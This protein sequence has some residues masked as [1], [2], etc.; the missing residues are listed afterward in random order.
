MATIRQELQA[1]LDAL[2]ASFEAEKAPLEAQLAKYDTWLDMEW[3]SF[4]A[5]VEALVA[6]ARTPT[7]A[8]PATAPPA[9][10]LVA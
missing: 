5:E 9:V 7:P 4:K 3:D 8:A 2:K 1:K 10:P 6:K